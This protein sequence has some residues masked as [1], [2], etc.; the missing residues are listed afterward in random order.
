MLTGWQKVNGDYFYFHNDG[1]MLTGW[2][3]DGTH[4]YYMDPAR[5]A[6]SH[7]WVQV[8]GYYHYF[9]DSGHC[10]T[11]WVRD[12]QTYYYLD[13]DNQGRMLAD[14]TRDIGGVSCSFGS[15]GAC[16][17]S[18]NVADAT[19]AG[20]SSSGTSASDGSSTPVVT[21][22]QKYSDGGPGVVR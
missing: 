21:S 18:V 1:Q 8:D 15:N 19:V 3:S 11:G 17:T 4:R 5:G 7:G 9:N 22:G 14:T 12:G 20:Q 16:L 13:P 6:M 2:L 10:I